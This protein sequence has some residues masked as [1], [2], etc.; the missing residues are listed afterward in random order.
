MDYE[1]GEKLPLQC[2]PVY[3]WWDRAKALVWTCIGAL[4]SAAAVA[5][6]L[7]PPV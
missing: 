5:W 4:L 7:G 6:L 1:H 3:T 2:R